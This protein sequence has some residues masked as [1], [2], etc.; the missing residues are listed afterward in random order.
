MRIRRRKRVVV[1]VVTDVNAPIDQLALQALS[2]EKLRVIVLLIIT[3]L[4]AIQSL[5]PPSMLSSDLGAA[6]Q[7][8]M[9]SFMRWRF[10]IV[11]FLIVYLVAQRLLVAYLI[12]THQGIPPVYPFITALIE[13]SMPTAGL[14]MA[15]TYASPGSPV[16]LIPVFLYHVFIVLSALRLSLFLSL[17]TGAVAAIE[18]LV[19]SRFYLD[20]MNFY[21]PIQVPIGISLLVLGC[22]HLALSVEKSESEW[23]KQT[24]SRRSETTSC[25]CSAATCRRRW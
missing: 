1:T 25:I 15:A 18:F 23:W 22:S 13:I 9:G 16:P 21:R 4:M 20:R 10:A 14:V 24:N 2:T 5:V 19:V 7:Q 8:N 17:F 12:K 6:L 11:G 3:G